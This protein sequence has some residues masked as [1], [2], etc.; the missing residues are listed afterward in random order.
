MDE[1]SPFPSRGTTS[2]KSHSI[3]LMLKTLSQRTI[4]ERRRKKS[5][6]SLLL[7][8]H[9]HTQ[10]QKHPRVDEVVSLGHVIRNGVC[11]RFAE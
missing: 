3:T 11:R 9:T 10:Q 4:A 5:F 1:H 7:D 8:S 2:R 6:V